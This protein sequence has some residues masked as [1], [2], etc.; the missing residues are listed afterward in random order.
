MPQ[1][2]RDSRPVARKAH[3][4]SS[5]NVRIEPGTRYHR[6]TNLYDGRAYDWIECD[7][8]EGLTSI[9]WDWAGQPDE[10]VVYDDFS[11]WAH[12][13]ESPEAAAW[14]ARSGCTCDDCT[15]RQP[16]NGAQE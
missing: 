6:A 10:G 1:L 7:A 12:E 4:C 16:Q 8:C 2:L 11:E 3:R 15:V 9:V 5:C 14:L 13:L